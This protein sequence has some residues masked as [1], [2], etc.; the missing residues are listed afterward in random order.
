MQQR[1]WGYHKLVPDLTLS[2]A[3]NTKISLDG[4]KKAGGGDEKGGLLFL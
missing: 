3:I 1:W 2:V 4:E